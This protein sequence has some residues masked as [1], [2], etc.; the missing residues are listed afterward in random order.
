MGHYL[1]WKK[2]A[3]ILASPSGATLIGPIDSLI[4]EDG[5]QNR[6]IMNY[7]AAEKRYGKLVTEFPALIPKDSMSEYEKAK[8]ASFSD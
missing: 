1:F 3:K 4:N 2:A 8:T 7:L 5:E 6:A